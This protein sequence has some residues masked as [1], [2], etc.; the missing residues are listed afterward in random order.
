[1][2]LLDSRVM[3]HP[4]VRL[5]AVLA[6]LAAALVP[7]TRAGA[8]AGAEFSLSVAVS[9]ALPLGAA[10]KAWSE[11]L[12]AS[13]SGAIAAKL[14]P[15]ATLARRDPSREFLALRDGDADLAVGSALA[16]SVQVPAFAVYATPW[17]APRP[18][19]LVALVE[20]GELFAELARRADASGVVLIHAA[21]LG[22]RALATVAK[23]VR[24]PA[25]LAGLAIRAT[26]GPLVV[27]AL[28]ALGARP[29]AMSFA[30][31]QAALAAGA[32]DG[33]E[34]PPTSFAAAR[35]PAAGYGQVLR[36]GA[37]GDAMLFAVRRAVWAAWTDDQRRAAVDTARNAALA[38]APL[39]A[40][41]DALARLAAQGMAELA[42]TAEGIEAFRS[43]AASAREAWRAHV[44]VDLVDIAQRVV[45][46]LP[47]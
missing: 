3:R 7:A 20:S 4:V 27:D 14:H 11:A 22:H 25:D 13:P 35:L 39:R 1:M 18:A 33:Q 24:S 10:A 38:A 15:G 17:I 43:A 21:P 40:E 28:A 41:D 36:W 16:W 44:G 8:G 32:I 29:Q 26:G 19:D 31:A 37:F 30:Q 47:R 9:P 6:F 23:P 12:A 34:G 46:A 5:V 45:A 42:P 2:A